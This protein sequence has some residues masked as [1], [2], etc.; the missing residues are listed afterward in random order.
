[1]GSRRGGRASIDI[2]RNNFGPSLLAA[3]TAGGLLLAGV[4]ACGVGLLV[5]SPVVY[6]FG[7]YTYRKLSGPPAAAQ[8][9]P[10]SNSTINPLA[11][12]SRL[13]SGS[14]SSALTNVLRPSTFDAQ[15]RIV[16]GMPIGVTLR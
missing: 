13:P 9:W 1:M 5:A 14:V 7:V 3:P 2:V 4:L 15:P 16:S 6:L 12:A 11:S 8:G 10:G